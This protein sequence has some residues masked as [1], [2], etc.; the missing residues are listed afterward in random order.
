MEKIMGFLGGGGG[1]HPFPPITGTCAKNKIG[2][3]GGWGIYF[4]PPPPGSCLMG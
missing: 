2:G 3:G 1:V 4:F